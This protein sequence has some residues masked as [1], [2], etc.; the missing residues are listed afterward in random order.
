MSGFASFI[1]ERGLRFIAHQCSLL[2]DQAAVIQWPEATTSVTENFLSRHRSQDEAPTDSSLHR[3]GVCFRCL[4]SSWKV[5]LLPSTYKQFPVSSSY[6]CL[7]TTLCSTCVC[8]PMPSGLF[9]CPGMARVGV[10]QQPTRL[11]TMA[12]TVTYC[13]CS[14]PCF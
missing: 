1:D 9:S 6:R 14:R 5:A 12:W 2:C 8:F 13:R 3:E 10:L 7:L 4:L 11:T